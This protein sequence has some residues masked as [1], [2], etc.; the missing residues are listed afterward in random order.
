MLFD[1][2]TS[3]IL[4]YAW[5]LGDEI[6]N[7]KFIRRNWFVLCWSAKWLGEKKIYRSSLPQ[8]RGYKELPNRT[9]KNIDE[10][11]V[12]GLW[13]LLNECN[14]AVAH[15]LRGF[16]RKKANT[17]FIINGM[18]P[19][20]HY[21]IVDTLTVARTQF[22]FTSNK[23]GYLADKLG[24]KHKLDAG[25]FDTWDDIEWGKAKAWRRMIKYCDGDLA[26]LEGI[27]EK[28]KPW[29]PRHPYHSASTQVLTEEDKGCNKKSC[30]GK[31]MVK[32][33]IRRT[34]SGMFQKFR[35]IGCGD[36]ILGELDNA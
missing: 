10:G 7:P 28:M 24:V 12:A 15:N 8:F 9:E 32:D 31:G 2:E 36:P 26:P 33:G 22:K 5:K 29:M 30:K 18:P 14:I 16:D 3:A 21:D 27:Y 11:V 6:W 17:R 1:L 19:P 20:S 13:K 25:G 34:K 35:C 4:L 23:L